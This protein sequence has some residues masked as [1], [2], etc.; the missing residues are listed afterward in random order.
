MLGVCGNTKHPTLNPK[1]PNR[2][3][4]SRLRIL[5]VDVISLIFAHGTRPWQIRRKTDEVVILL[6]T[7]QGAPWQFPEPG[8]WHCENSHIAR[9]LHYALLDAFMQVYESSFALA[10]N[11]GCSSHLDRK[12]GWQLENGN[13]ACLGSRI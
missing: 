13:T 6:H 2:S 5:S 1:P 12:L 7:L 8:I 3:I 11:C 9:S 4:A 10:W